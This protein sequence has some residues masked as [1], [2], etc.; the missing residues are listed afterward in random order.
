MP[1]FDIRALCERASEKDL[2][3]YVIDFHRVKRNS[4]LYVG[5]SD[6]NTDCRF[7]HYFT[8]E[9]TEKSLT[10]YSTD[11]AF[12]KFN[13]LSLSLS[14]RYYILWHF[15][16]LHA[17]ALNVAQHLISLVFQRNDAWT[18]VYLRI[19]LRTFLNNVTFLDLPLNDLARLPRFNARSFDKRK[20]VERAKSRSEIFPPSFFSTNFFAACKPS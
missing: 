17:Y 1:G 18:N 9:S 11:I 8:S 2:R 6:T 10:A 13:P 7:S 3:Y 4:V 19:E 15:F 14:H 12:S 5:R 16:P 20:D